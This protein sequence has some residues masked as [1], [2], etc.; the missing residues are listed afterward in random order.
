[1]DYRA[2]LRALGAYDELLIIPGTYTV[3]GKHIS[4][5]RI[6]RIYVSQPNSCYNG[7]QLLP[8][9]TYSSTALALIHLFEWFC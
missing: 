9:A 5:K 4:G 6:T 3:P 8:S 7:E 2:N 1:M